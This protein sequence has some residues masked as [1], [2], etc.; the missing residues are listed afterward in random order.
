[1]DALTEFNAIPVKSKESFFV[2]QEILFQRS[3]G[4]PGGCGQ[5]D[6]LFFG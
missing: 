1:M 6:F 4:L 3:A 2:S 5:Q